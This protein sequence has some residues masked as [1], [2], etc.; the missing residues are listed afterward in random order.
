MAKRPAAL[1]A[2]KK[3]PEEIAKAGIEEH[4]YEPAAMLTW[5]DYGDKVVVVTMDGKRFE[6][7][8]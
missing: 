2:A 8:K 3:S 6:I 7:V 5:K 4:G 1:K